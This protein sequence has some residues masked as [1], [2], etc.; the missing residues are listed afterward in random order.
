MAKGR[1]RGFTGLGE[2]S[3]KIIV[4][5]VGALISSVRSKPGTSDRN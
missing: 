4:L 1:C 3:L 5:K 2:D